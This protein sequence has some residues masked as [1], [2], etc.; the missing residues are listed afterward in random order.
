M[1]KLNSLKYITL[2]TALV[3]LLM[4]SLISGVGKYVLMCIG[5][6]FLIIAFASFASYGY[7]GFKTKTGY[8]V[9]RYVIALL[10]LIA[11]GLELVI[12]IARHGEVQFSGY[13]IICWFALATYILMYKPSECPKAYKTMK[14]FGYLLILASVNALQ[15][16]LQTSNNLFEDVYIDETLLILIYIILIIGITLIVIANRKPNEYEDPVMEDSNKT[17]GS[18]TP[19]KKIFRYIWISFGLILGIAGIL[20]CFDDIF[21]NFRTPEYGDFGKYDPSVDLSSLRIGDI[22]R[23]P[24][25]IVSN[26]GGNRIVHAK[27][28]VSFLG[29]EWDEID[30]EMQSF[31]KHEYGNRLATLVSSDSNQNSE[32]YG[33]LISLMVYDLSDLIAQ[34][35]GNEAKTYEKII[36]TE[37]SDT[38]LYKRS[39]HFSPTLGME[40]PVYT[41]LTR[42][43]NGELIPYSGKNIILFANSR[44]YHLSFFVLKDSIQKSGDKT[45]NIL[46]ARSITMAQ[47]LDLHSYNEWLAGAKKFIC[48]LTIKS[49]IFAGLYLLCIAAAVIFLFLYF[50]KC[51]NENKKA[52]KLC[53]II[54]LFGIVSCILLGISLFEEFGTINHDSF[55]YNVI[56]YH[57]YDFKASE[58]ICFYA[59]YFLFVIVLTNIV[60]IK[61]YTVP[62]TPSAP[63]GCIYYMVR[64]IVIFMNLFKKSKAFIKCIRQEYKRQTK[65]I[66]QNTTNRT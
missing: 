32:T 58:S 15:I 43:E 3:F 2:G 37:V 10:I 44:A 4:S 11:A 28:D 26:N 25:R 56:N 52:A 63:K 64:P 54:S 42:D 49:W 27:H 8:T 47:Q 48:T 16:V 14:C 23:I 35:E 38:T 60:Y 55:Y 36:S 22:D 1:K 6:V 66:D 17:D 53:R 20:A 41:Y 21:P 9:A 29:L 19:H 39:K 13:S 65:E 46:E 57:I 50:I 30:D 33:H 31:T 61:S 62:T 5:G 7:R 18:I 59:F 51:G 34:N 45:F 40:T 12:L 24:S